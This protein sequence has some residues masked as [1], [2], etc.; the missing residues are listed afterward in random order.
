MPKIFEI[1]GY[2]F[3][4]FSNEGQP[5]EPCHIHVKKN[6]NRAKFWIE[7]MVTFGSAW[8]MSAK[9]LNYLE[10][11]VEEKSNIIKER[12]YEHFNSGI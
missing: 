2:K 10:K 12:W 7:P 3:F 5:L 4:F 8:G 11:I 6:G 9:E 1:K